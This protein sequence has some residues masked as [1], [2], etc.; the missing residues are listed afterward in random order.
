MIDT[1]A[2]RIPATAEGWRAVATQNIGRLPGSSEDRWPRTLN[3]R[4]AADARM[5][6]I[7][8]GPITPRTHSRYAILYTAQRVFPASSSVLIF[9]FV[10]VAW[11]AKFVRG[12]ADLANRWFAQ[13]TRSLNMQ[14][15]VTGHSDL[16][17]RTRPL[18]SAKEDKAL[19][20][21]WYEHHDVAATRRLIGGHLYLVAE[22][23][24]A[25]RGCGMGTQELIG[26]GYVG[27]MHA[28]CRYDP[29][30]GI[31]FA[32]YATSWVQAAIQQSILRALPSMPAGPLDAE[33]A[34]AVPPPR[35][36]AGG[37]RGLVRTVS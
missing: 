31:T 34:T 6:A 3:A 1:H 11:S 28:A 35:A 25:H 19:C 2:P 20:G 16:A 21:R 22:S 4:R 7:V 9:R 12:S 30:S 23:A 37:Q 33:A 36:R 32:T 29:R 5:I 10:N 24:A 27:L 26:E 18:L 15:T 14:A 8:R 17:N 13:L